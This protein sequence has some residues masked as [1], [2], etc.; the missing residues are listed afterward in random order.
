MCCGVGMIRYDVSVPD[1]VLDAVEDL[2]RRAEGT[3]T[4]SL[5]SQ[6]QRPLQ[7]TV[8]DLFGQYPGP[9]IHPFEFSTDKS[10]RY[11]FAKFVPKGSKGGSYIRKGKP[12]LGW[13]VN[14]D[15]R[16]TGSE[17]IIYN[18]WKNSIYVYGGVTQRQVPGHARTGWGGDFE[19]AAS[20]AQERG[21]DLLIAAWVMAVDTE[22]QKL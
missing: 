14:I 16:R 2:P 21:V 3:F 20:L 8:T 6:V 5:D 18:Q 19:T 22:V 4:N 11:Y 12:P 9:V 13:T 10:R 17:L 7:T 15:L 1:D